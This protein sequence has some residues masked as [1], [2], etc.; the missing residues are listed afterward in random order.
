MLL[1]LPPGRVRRALGRYPAG[2]GLLAAR[3]VPLPGPGPG[4]DGG[5]LDIF[6]EKG[7]K[8][9]GTLTR[10]PNLL[11]AGKKL[12]KRRNLGTERNGGKPNTQER[13]NSIMLPKDNV[14]EEAAC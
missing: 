6:A 4:P 9:G 3:A 14:A 1:L 8:N 2:L 5:R 12:E 11:L 10:N 13:E 7:K